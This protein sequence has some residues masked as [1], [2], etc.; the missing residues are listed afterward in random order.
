MKYLKQEHQAIST[1]L[2]FALIPL[3]GFATDIYLPSLPSMA[4]DLSVSN[5]AVQFS[6]IIFMV[7]SGIS[8]LFVGSL[9]DS[10]GRYRLGI[11][12][13]L[14][15]VLA[16]FTIAVTDNIY[17]IYLMRVIHGITIAIIV[18]GKRAYFVDRFSGDKL[19]HFTSLFSIIWATA[20]IIAPF[21][22]GY[23]QVAFGWESNF[24]FLGILTALILCLELIY[25]GETLKHLQPF[26]LNRIA[27]VYYTTIKTADFSLGLIIIGL[28]YAMLMVYGMTG[29]FIIEHVF[30]YSPVIT[31]YCS[32]LSGVA[33][34][35][36][37]MVS[38]TFIR[39]PLTRKIRIG[40]VLQ[41]LCAIGLIAGSSFF[42]NIFFL[43]TMVLVIHLL[44]GFL[45]N[46]FFSYCL[47]RFSTNAGIASGIT[48]GSMYI[49]TS[50][51]S[52]GV[53]NALNIKSMA[54]LGFGY[55]VLNL[56]IAVFFLLF[57]KVKRTDTL[58]NNRQASFLPGD[59]KPAVI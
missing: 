48:G 42:Q 22:G 45:F 5:T 41:L 37:G 25:G 18:V 46:N 39:K 36:G 11:M 17:L 38:K 26:N 20:P 43:M 55:L 32:L 3:S 28:C 40:I 30:N 51:F 29:P 52:Y 47:G 1:I 44:S 31:G 24:Y 14:V 9:L 54:L 53:I 34:M 7:S 49:I 12:A 8:Q 59:S 4:T 35:I 21:L 19:K 13:L 23:L 33:L 15:F 16:S 57:N 58:V 50:I 27:R 2:S 10:F 56:L 6:L